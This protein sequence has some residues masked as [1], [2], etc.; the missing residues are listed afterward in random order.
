MWRSIGSGYT[1]LSAALTLA[2]AGRSVVVL[3]PGYARHRRQFAQ[4]RHAGQCVE[5]VARHADAPLRCRSAPG[6]CLPKSREAYDFLGRFI[7]E[8]KI[9]CDYAETGG[10]TGIVKPAHYEAL[11]RETEQL[12]RTIGLEAHMVPKSEVRSEI[13]TDLYCGGRVMHRRAGLHPARYHA[14]LIGRVRGGRR[15]GGRQQPGHRN[16]NATAATSR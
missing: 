1:G 11:A 16:S 13:G 3:E 2:R 7:A 8:E 5:A 9:D 6:R 12:S 15:D 4:R 10:F 14:G